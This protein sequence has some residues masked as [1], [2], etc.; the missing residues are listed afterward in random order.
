[1]SHLTCDINT[2]TFQLQTLMQ[3]YSV[4]KYWCAIRARVDTRHNTANNTTLQYIDSNVYSTIRRDTMRCIQRSS[5][6]VRYLSGSLARSL[7]E[8]W[9]AGRTGLS[10]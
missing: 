6:T 4:W 5:E 2:V 10:T 3:A 1:M 9:V 7:A 8:A